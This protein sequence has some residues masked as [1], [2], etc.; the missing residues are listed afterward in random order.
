MVG[1]LGRVVVIYT[2]THHTAQITLQRQSQ[3]ATPPQYR[4]D[5]VTSTAVRTI[6]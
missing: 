4:P 1:G 2:E 3:P 5:L 6:P